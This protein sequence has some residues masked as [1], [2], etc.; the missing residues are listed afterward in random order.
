MGL[1]QCFDCT[2]IAPD[3]A[4]MGDLFDHQTTTGHQGFG[5]SP[6]YEWDDTLLAFVRKGTR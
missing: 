5:P 6:E 4:T 3:G 2:W 1:S